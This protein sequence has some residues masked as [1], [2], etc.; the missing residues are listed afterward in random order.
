MRAPLFLR[1]NLETLLFTKFKVPACYIAEAPIL[2][3]YSYGTM[4]GLVMDVGETSAQVVPIYDGHVIERAVKRVAYLGGEATTRKMY[5]FLKYTSLSRLDPIEAFKVAQK[6]KEK[7]CFVAKNFEEALKDTAKSKKCVLPGGEEITLQ[8][9]LPSVGEIYFSPAQ[10]LGDKEFKSLPEL[11]AEAI[12]ACDMD[13]RRAMMEWVLLSGGDSMLPGLPERLQKGIIELMPYVE[14]FKMHSDRSR[15]NA[16]WNG[17]SVLAK[18]DYFQ[19][20]WVEQA[21]WVASQ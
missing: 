1:K 5:N 12:E 21:E 20:N 15:K 6:V 3:C 11:V 16:V 7:Y 10:Q 14:G 2:V 19:K 13:T 8:R 17:G 9:A 18:L 4:T